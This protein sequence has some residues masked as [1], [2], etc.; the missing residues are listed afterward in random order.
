MMGA[1]ALLGDWTSYSHILIVAAALCLVVVIMLALRALSDYLRRWRENRRMCAEMQ[2]SVRPST[3]A[4]TAPR[5]EQVVNADSASQ[6]ALGWSAE[7]DAGG[8][9]SWQGQPGVE[10][11]AVLGREK[12]I[13]IADDDPVV[14]LALSRRLQ[15]LGFQ[16]F[17]SPDAAHALMGVMKIRPD[18]VILDVNMP[19]GNGLA[20]CEMMSCDRQCANI[21]V[22]VH[23]VFA[24][25][26]VKRRCQQLGAH[27]VE[28]SPHSWAEIK[29]LVEALI[30]ENKTAQPQPAVPPSQ[31][32]SKP[33]VANTA[34]DDNAHPEPIDGDPERSE[35]SGVDAEEILRCD[36]DDGRKNDDR[37]ENPRVATSPATPQ[38]TPPVCG[39]SRVL[40]I[41]SP[42]D[43]LELVD[44]QLSAFELEV[45]RV[46]D[47]EEGFWTCFTEK[48][49]VIIIQ[50]AEDR[51]KLLELL[52]RLAE[53][54][55]TR[56]LPVLLINEGDAIANNELPPRGNVKIVKHP[57]DWEDL[58][59]EL[60]KVLPVFAP[61]AGDPL[62]SIAHP[63]PGTSGA[64]N[65][66][67][68]AQSPPSGAAAE[69]KP[70][71]VLCIDDDPVVARSI[72]I[73]LQPYGIKVKGADSGTQG[74]LMA[75]TEQPDLI[76]LDL[77][78]PNGEGN[79]VLSK[80]KDNEHTKEI[81]V[82]ILTIETH[83]GVRR[84]MLSAGAAA[85]VT[86]PVH[87]PELFAEM[88]HCI[89][90]PEQLMADYRLTPQLTLSQ[91]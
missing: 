8:S 61:E 28:K 16:V 33:P 89:Q 42:R 50:G 64:N 54:P 69:Q 75:V 29:S 1:I 35:G 13:L 11:G 27:H 51:K 5:V 91:L 65:Q 59:G 81:P 73:R 49:H 85:F 77:K 52:R 44:H 24:D 18:L 39:R 87:W 25:K 70:L 45:V 10:P 32:A 71:K 82:I 80:L 58:L 63:S 26:A 76:L 3:P 7:D 47:L 72:A 4:G 86:K 38:R 19:S 14:T 6:D 62:A 79:Y 56:A 90:L 43:R 17:R 37:R 88:G 83:S 31:T 78:M 53:H 34:Q 21:P 2:T 20:V 57:M 12:T 23:S 9:V 60:E 55:V 40:C 68:G 46:S 84:Q 36:Q 74:Y 66:L 67:V 15:H 22:I 48:P 41:E 30:G